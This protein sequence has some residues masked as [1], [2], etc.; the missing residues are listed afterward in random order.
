MHRAL[1]A[2]FHLV[3]LNNGWEWWNEEGQ[4]LI[5]RNLKDATS[6]WVHTQS[7]SMYASTF[8]HVVQIE[9]KKK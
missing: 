8:L 7:I 1:I 5:E 6:M 4:L 2:I 3:Q 9:K